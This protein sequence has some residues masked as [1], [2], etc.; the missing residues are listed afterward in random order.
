[1]VIGACL[2]IP[3]ALWEELGGFPE[4]FGSIAED[5]YLCCRARLAGYAVR[6]LAASGYRHCQGNS[7][8]G[9]KVEANRLAT[10]VRRRAL[11]ERNKTFVMMMTCPTLAIQMLLPIHLLLLLIE[12]MLL[13]IFKFR[14]DLLK[15]IYLP[16][17]I[18]IMWN[19]QSWVGVRRQAMASRRSSSCSFFS[20]FTLMPHKARLLW[21][22][23]V[24]Q[25][26]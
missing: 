25:V 9:G 15:R 4:W 10:T 12:G 5:M 8:G 16:A 11:S 18:E 14:F 19:D 21:R 6:A 22:H 23:G 13:S 26:R 7:F 3:R 1:M 2:W 17:I 20:T 24:P